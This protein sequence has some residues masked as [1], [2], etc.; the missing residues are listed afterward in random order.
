MSSGSSQVLPTMAEG[1]ATASDSTLAISHSPSVD[2]EIDI[3]AADGAAAG[4]DDD[5]SEEAIQAKAK[6]LVKRRVSLQPKKVV[7]QDGPKDSVPEARA[8]ARASIANI[9]SGA[10]PSGAASMFNAPSMEGS[11]GKGEVAAMMIN[12]LMVEAASL[13]I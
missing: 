6:E 4:A 5:E 13:S 10:A 1:G 8:K 7:A 9:M 3:E 2:V 12:D 11:Y